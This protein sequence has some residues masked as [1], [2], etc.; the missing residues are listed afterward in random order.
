MKTMRKRIISLFLAILMLL[1]VIPMGTISASAAS[2]IQEKLNKVRAVYDTGSYFTTASSTAKCSSYNHDVMNG[3]WCQ[4]CY[5]P[6][7]PSRGGLP[8]GGA[9]GYAS[10]TCCGFASY[11]FYCV[12]GHNHTTN[13]N[14]TSA[15]VFGDLVFTG[16][17]WF[18]YLSED[19]TNYYVYDANGYNGGKNKV[20]YNNYYPKSS[21]SA[22]T[23]YHAANYNQINNTVTHTHSYS[24]S[25]TKQPT[26]TVAGVRTYKCSCGNS[27]TNAIPATGH[28]WDE[29]Q[30]TSASGCT[31]EGVKKFT[32]TVCSETRTEAISAT[33][34]TPVTDNMVLP[35]CTKQGLSEGSHCS[36]CNSVIKEQTVIPALGHDYKLTSYSRTCDDVTGAYKCSKCGDRYEETDE[37]IWSDWSEKEPEDVSSDLIEEKTLYRYSLKETTQSDKNSLDGW[38]KYKSE[39]TDWTNWSAWQNSSITATDSREV[40]T[41]Y[42]KPTYKTVWHYSRDTGGGYSTYA[43]GYYGNPEYITLNYRL[44]AKGTVD[45]YTRYGS[46]GNYLADY[47]WNESSESVVDKAG[48]TQYSYR[49]AIYTHYYYKWSDMS[50]WQETP[51]EENDNTNVET[52]TVYRYKIMPLENENEEPTLD[53]ISIHSKPTKTVYTVGETFSSSGLSINV[54]MSDGTCKTVTSGFAVSKPDMATAG[55]KTVTVTYEGKTTTFTITVKA[56]DT[57]NPSIKIDAGKAGCGQ[58]IRIPVIVENTDLSTLE[59][60]ITYDSSKLK[61]VSVDDMPFDTHYANIKTSG[62]IR[63][64]ASDDTGV[65]AGRI[66]VLTFDV[67]ADDACSTEISVTVNEAYDSNDNSVDLTVYNKAL[68]IINVLSGDAN[69][70]GIIDAND[71]AM[72]RSCVMC[73]QNMTE[74]QRIAADYNR[75][76]VVDAFDVI[77]IDVYICSK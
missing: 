48:Y 24:S 76:G 59:M 65:S 15:P 4:G 66:A 56:V 72:V 77:A 45:G 74:E 64:A 61:I 21:V 37:Y 11:V 3:E 68:E 9:V 54:N 67:I 25:V 41:Q 47:W 35:T 8:S 26:C 60:N 6:N 73:T 70:D 1:P 53:F 58:R 63:L 38:T 42:I 7:I 36:K 29:G 44:T 30:V 75:D 69:D 32:C 51:V 14:C 39:I 10:D 49:D 20:I 31:S 40:K 50:D 13:T 52:S 71:Y 5:L 17:H 27:Y 28:K 34:H 43:I 16:S 19:S 57:N 12:F 46:Y 22:L 33:G 2:G 62:K 23:V 18:I 55:T